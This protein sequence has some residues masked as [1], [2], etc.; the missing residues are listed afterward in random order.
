METQPSQQPPPRPHGLT[1]WAWRLDRWMQRQFGTPYRVVLSIGLV[2]SISATWEA[3]AK[4]IH[5]TTNI[6]V[7]IAT[8]LFQTALLINQLAQ[9]HQRRRARVRR[10]ALKRTP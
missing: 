4:S 8:V 9:M 5:S 3:L 2:A 1:Y 7:T 6:A 10:Q